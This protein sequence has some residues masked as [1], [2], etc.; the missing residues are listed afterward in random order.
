MEEKIPGRFPKNYLEKLVELPEGII[1]WNPKE[2]SWGNPVLFLWRLQHFT[3]QKYFSTNYRKDSLRI[4]QEFTGKFFEEPPKD[5]IWRDT[6]R[7]WSSV[8]LPDI[9]EVFTEVHPEFFLFLNYLKEST[10]L[11]M[12]SQKDF[13]SNSKWGLSGGIFVWF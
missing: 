12:V 7:N 2:I 11:N 8:R 9:L 1:G 6:R 10:K 3:K 5:T 13:R 4:L